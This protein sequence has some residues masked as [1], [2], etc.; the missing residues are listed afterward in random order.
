MTRPMKHSTLAAGLAALVL[1]GCAASATY[2][3]ADGTIEQT[4][5]RRAASGTGVFFVAPAIVVAAWDLFV[6]GPV[7]AADSIM[8]GSAY[9]RCKSDLES[10]GFVRVG[11]P[12][13]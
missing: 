4:C 5:V 1:S 9:A 10:A 3:S 7:I 13:P 11:E 8:A 2:R 12:Q 6:E